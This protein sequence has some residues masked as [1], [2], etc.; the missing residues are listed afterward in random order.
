[1]E[2]ILVQNIV[3][4]T[5]FFITNLSKSAYTVFSVKISSAFTKIANLVYAFRGVE[6]SVIEIPIPNQDRKMQNLCVI[7]SN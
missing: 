7:K 6:P 1:M 4:Y 5:M 2:T 3:N